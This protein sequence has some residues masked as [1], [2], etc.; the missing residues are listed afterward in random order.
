MMVKL[1]QKLS[2]DLA[3]VDKS[4]FLFIALAVILF[5]VAESF[6]QFW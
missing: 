5:N 4:L 6:I 1:F 2:T 3:E